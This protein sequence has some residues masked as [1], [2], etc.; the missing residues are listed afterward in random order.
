[1]KIPAHWVSLRISDNVPPM[2]NAQR[3]ASVPSQVI[4][5]RLLLARRGTWL[6][7]SPF[8][9]C[10]EE[11]HLFPP[12]SRLRYCQELLLCNSFFLFVCLAFWFCGHL[13]R[14]GK[15]LFF[16]YSFSFFFFKF[17]TFALQ[18]KFLGLLPG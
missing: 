3:V 15:Y 17:K 12:P 1:M 7:L 5:S 4:S 2:G 11:I 16:S 13:K 9:A 6:V 18:L 8:A 14:A 10:E